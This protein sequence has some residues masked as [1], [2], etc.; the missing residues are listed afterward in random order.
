MTNTIWIL[1]SFVSQI[2]REVVLSI[3]GLRTSRPMPAMRYTLP[4][5][6]GA[7][8]DLGDVEREL[9]RRDERVL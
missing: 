9:F 2:R 3:V 1:R 6:Y 7:R 5:P 4:W 8:D